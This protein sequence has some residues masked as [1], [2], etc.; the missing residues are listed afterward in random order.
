VFKTARYVN[1]YTREEGNM[2]V[3]L[4]FLMSAS[5][6]YGQWNYTGDYERELIIMGLAFGMRMVL[7]REV[8]Q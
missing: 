7:G 5:V 4:M 3:M 8:F 1:I 6:A 2:R